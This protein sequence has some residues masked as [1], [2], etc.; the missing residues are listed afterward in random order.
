MATL[1]LPSTGRAQGV[2]FVLVAGLLWSTIPLGVRFMESATAAQIVFWRAA[3]QVP[4]LIA[5]L[6]VRYRGRVV[7]PVR[8]IGWNGVWGAFALAIAYVS[9]MAAL[10]LTTVGNAV[11]VLSTAPLMT[12]LLA[13]LLL[14]ERLK[15][16][17]WIAMGLASLGVAVMTVAAVGSGQLAGNVAAAVSAFGYAVFTVSLRRGRTGDMLPTIALSGVLAAIMAA[18]I[19]D[20]LTVSS[21]DLAI[22]AYLGAFG[23]GLGLVLYTAGSKTLSAAELPLVA[24]IEV[25][26]APIWVWLFL[27]EAIDAATFLGGAIVLAAVLIQAL[28][29][30][31]RERLPIGMGT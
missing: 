7:K 23:I 6:L 14:K 16:T 24:M 2:A 8:S 13:R 26:L 29:G 15:R 18:F 1:A 30:F 21:G 19:A 28:L 10:T 11:F 12:A 31:R 22:A 17:T 20:G 4:V 5:I 25:V 9:G 27:G 3:V